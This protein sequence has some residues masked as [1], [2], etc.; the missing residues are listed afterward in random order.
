MKA[1]ISMVFFK[2]RVTLGAWTR[3]L[4][5]DETVDPTPFAEYESYRKSTDA[6]H[7]RELLATAPEVFDL[8]TWDGD[9]TGRRIQVRGN[10]LMVEMFGTPSTKKRLYVFLSAGGGAL[11]DG[12][13][14][15]F[16]RVSWHSWMDGVSL[17]IDDPTFVA[18]P[19][20]L[21][22]GWYLGTPDQDAVSTIAAIVERVLSCYAVDSNDLYIIGSSAG[23]TAALK[24]AAEIPG[25]TAVVEN[26]PIY[27][28]ESSSSRHLNRVGLRLND[29]KLLARTDLRHILRHES[30]RFIVLQNAEDKEIL[31]QLVRLLASE[32]MPPP[33]IGLN[34]AGPLSVYVSSVP[35]LS[36]HHTFLSVHEFR[37]ILDSLQRGELADARAA[38]FDAVYEGLRART[39]ASDELSNIKGWIRL[40]RE[41]DVPL[42]ADPPLPSTSNIVRIPLRDAPHVIYRLRMG[43]K[44]KKIFIAVNVDKSALAS[45][46]DIERV[47]QSIGGTVSKVD[48]GMRIGLANVPM[49]RAAELLKHFVEAT[50]TLIT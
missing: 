9:V 37:S 26:P 45:R 40:W 16:P 15:Q 6:L 27:P 38:V 48:S 31:D 32:G 21:Q 4:S 36:P 14:A 20:R 8:A 49:Q 22:T 13:T 10:G 12:V 23:G 28:A 25:A 34:E 24:L 29:K 50:S 19:G 3:P 7:S 18:Y 47:A 30:S 2:R 11:K 1:T 39:R 33:T 41:A 17:N 42:L 35:A 5:P 43:H 44:G 46:A